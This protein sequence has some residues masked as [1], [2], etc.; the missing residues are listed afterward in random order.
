MLT[1][2]S[3]H[4]IGVLTLAL[5]ASAGSADAGGTSTGMV[6]ISEL[7]PALYQGFEGGLYPLGLNTP[8]AAHAAAAHAAAQQIVPRDAAGEVDF[9]NGKIVMVAIGMSNTTHEF[10]PFERQEDLNPSRHARV[11]LLDTA[12]GGQ[13]AAEIADPTA[14]YWTTVTSRVAAAGGSNNQVQVAWLKEANANPTAAFPLH[15]QELRDHLESIAR[16]LHD[17]F[18]N[19]RIAYLSSRTYGG[20][21]IGTLNPEPFAY[22]SAFSVKWAIEDQING[23]P[24]LNF[25]PDVGPVEAPVMLWGPYLWADGLTPRADG[26]IWDITDFEGDGTH[27]SPSGE[28]KVGDL[29]SGFFGTDPTAGPWWDPRPGVTLVSVDANADATVDSAAPNTNFGSQTQLT[30]VSAASTRRTFI[31]FD[32]SSVDRPVR[33]AKLSLRIVQSGGNP[34][35]LVTDSSWNENTIT[36]NNAP[37][38]DGGL[39]VNVP[40]SSRDGTLAAEVT[41]AVNSDTDGVITFAFT[42]TFGQGLSYHSKEAGQ[43]PRLIL[44][45]AVP[46]P[47]CPGDANGDSVVNFGDVTAVL[48]NF[49]NTYPPNSGGAGD[50]NGD[51]N[52]NFADVTAVLANFGNTC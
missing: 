14:P 36:W 9:A 40:R 35:S 48:A 16:N 7:P 23:D 4:R 8:P 42:E 38:I 30:V 17:L 1:S 34:V 12:F 18:P 15:A 32:V 21:A 44:T 5:M 19:L 47:P 49:G 41:N 33:Y 37:A 51:G 45:V 6:P 29:L 24:L 25:D 11:L 3:V 27:P 28:Q 50:A 39:V 22:E 43:P 10:A 26:L 20:Y 52:V 13:T 31:R 46:P 2:A